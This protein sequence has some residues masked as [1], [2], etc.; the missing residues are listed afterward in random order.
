MCWEFDKS[1]FEYLWI[2]EKTSRFS[3]FYEL[4]WVPF[5]EKSQFQKQITIWQYASIWDKFRK[6]WINPFTAL[7]C[8]LEMKKWYTRDDINKFILEILEDKT[9]FN[10]I[11][12]AFWLDS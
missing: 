9:R 5:N 7:A 10:D 3:K 8:S 12:K 6:A 2:N 11:Y 4:S 1:V